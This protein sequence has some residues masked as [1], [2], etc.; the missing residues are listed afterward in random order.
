MVFGVH[1]LPSGEVNTVE[2]E[3]PATHCPP[4]QPM[5]VPVLDEVV[6]QT[7]PFED[8]D[9]KVPAPAHIHPFQAI[10]VPAAMDVVLTD[11]NLGD[12]S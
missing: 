7:M 2:V 11:H 3:V 6:C 1:V 12:D 8:E 5:H 4:P 10:L 9:M